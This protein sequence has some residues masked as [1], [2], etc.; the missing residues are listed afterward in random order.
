MRPRGLIVRRELRRRSRRW[1]LFG[2]RVL[3]PLVVAALLAIVL[4]FFGDRIEPD[5][6]PDIGR[7]MYIA[8][9]ICLTILVAVVVPASIAR[10]VQVERDEG[11]LDLLA[12]T[13]ISPAQGLFGTVGTS[14][15][16]LLLVVLGTMP[17]VALIPTFGGVAPGEVTSLVLVLPAMA[18]VL[19]AVGGLTGLVSRSLAMPLIVTGVF[20][21]T[22]GFL[23]PLRLAY[24]VFRASGNQT[25]DVEWHTLMP[26]STAYDGAVWIPWGVLPWL[27]IAVIALGVSVWRFR[28]AV[29]TGWDPRSKAWPGLRGGWAVHLPILALGVAIFEGILLV[30]PS[31]HAAPAMHVIP[32]LSTSAN[33]VV[34]ILI[35]AATWFSAAL[36]YLRATVWLIPRLS[37]PRTRRWVPMFGNPITWRELFTTAH[38][39]LARAMGILTVAWLV[40]AV[41]LPLTSNEE[42]FVAA[43]GVLAA[44]VTLFV[45]MLLIS[46]SITDERRRGTLPLLCSTTIPPFRIVAGKTVAVAARVL[47]LAILGF[48]AVVLAMPEPFFGYRGVGD[49]SWYGGRSPWGRNLLGSV[50]WIRIPVTLAWIAGFWLTF[51]LASIGLAVRVRN[52]TLAWITPLLLGVSV[53][54]LLLLTMVLSANVARRHA[55]VELVV[56]AVFPFQQPFFR[57]QAAGLPPELLVS[58]A[59]W[60]SAALLALAL[61]T[62]WMKRW[63]PTTRR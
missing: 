28:R 59:V 52:L 57:N 6:I 53:P 24:A 40:I 32:G 36:L 42:E 49:W 50:P 63:G 18:L 54:P 35:A 55:W 61:A 30:S 41:L 62:A 29:G 22:F 8:A 27:G 13:G 47:P 26:L 58:S 21:L 20:A 7:A 4:G 25:A 56:T 34:L 48:A 31:G 16:S 3:P 45:A 5:Q 60:W 23:L 33:L 10:A 9:S 17:L 12:L 11:T 43:W 1:Q 14:L 44:V 19:G 15:L 37:L 2:L 38:G 39:G 51:V 46:T